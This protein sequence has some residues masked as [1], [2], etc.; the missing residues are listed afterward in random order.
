MIRNEKM[1]VFRKISGELTFAEEPPSPRPSM[2]AGLLTVRTHSYPRLLIAVKD[3][4]V[5]IIQHVCNG[6]NVLGVVIIDICS[7]IRV[8]PSY[9]TVCLKCG[10]SFFYR[11]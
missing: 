6:L 10:A 1:L 8:N 3:L 9:L 4:N 2:V 11:E 7:F 5:C